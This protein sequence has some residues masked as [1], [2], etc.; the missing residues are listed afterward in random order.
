M[1]LLDFFAAGL[2][3]YPLLFNNNILVSCNQRC[4]AGRSRSFLAGDG[5]DLKFELQP[6]PIFLGQLRLLFSESV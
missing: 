5:A 3:S 2:W 1:D 6:E 4:G